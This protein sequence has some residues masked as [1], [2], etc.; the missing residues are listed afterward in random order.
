MTICGCIGRWKLCPIRALWQ[1]VL[2]C[3]ALSALCPVHLVPCAILCRSCALWEAVAAWQAVPCA[4]M[5][6]CHAVKLWKLW[7]IVRQI[8]RSC[9]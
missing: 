9:Q 8:V 1:A 7:Q 2:P 3:A 4:V 6:S 5:L